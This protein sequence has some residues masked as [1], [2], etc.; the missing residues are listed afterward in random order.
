M[1]R[2]GKQQ[3]AGSSGSTLRKW[4]FLF[5]LAG[6]AGRGVIQTH[7]L[8]IGTVTTQELLE[9]MNS[10]GDVMILVTAAL[11]LQA[12]ETC[13]APMFAM[14]LVEGFRHTSSLRSYV[15]RV[16]GTAVLAEIPYNLAMGGSWLDLSSRN[17]MFGLVL[18]LVTL[19]LYRRYGEKTWA[20]RGIRAV[21]AVA[22]VV[23]AEMLGIDFGTAMVVLTGT[24]WAFR[25]KPMFRN[26]AGMA[27]AMLCS[28]TSWFFLAS[29]MGFL[30]LHYYNGEPGEQ[31]KVGNYLF[32]P[33]V[34]LLAGVGCTFLFA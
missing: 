28:I 20:H 12:M 24:L 8:G 11:V 4:A 22:A 23:W 10:S 7:M 29:P 14:L 34:L 3:T 31:N 19:W 26:Y 18:C 15:L 16:L 27:A 13:A 6:V 17:P 25:K 1:E 30:A 5:L 32:Y 9:A 2:L 33:V 21:V